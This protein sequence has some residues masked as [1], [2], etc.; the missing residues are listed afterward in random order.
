M[1]TY[2]GL[3][4]GATLVLNQKLRRRLSNNYILDFK[5]SI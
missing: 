2:W 1:R 5:P 4:A 3:I